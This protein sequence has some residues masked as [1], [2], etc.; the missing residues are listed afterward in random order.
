MLDASGHEVVTPLRKGPADYSLGIRSRRV[1]LLGEFAHCVWNCE[2]GDDRFLDLVAN[3][4]FDVLCHHAAEVGEYR[5]A[6]FDIYQAIVANTHRLR[7]VLRTMTKRGLRAAVS[8]GTVFQAG[9]G[10]GDHADR[11]VSAYGL[12]KGLSSQIFKFYCGEQHVS[13]GEFVIPN[14]FGPLEEARFCSYLVRCW[15]KGD[16]AKV[17]TPSYVRDNIHVSLLALVYTKFIEDLAQGDV[18]SRVCRPSG[19]VETQGDFAERFAREMRARL[20]LR[21]ELELAEQTE[22]PEPLVRINSQPA[23]DILDDVSLRESWRE[24]LAWQDLA[25]Y[26]AGPRP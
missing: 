18:T 6:D 5:S 17:N 1:D 20:N 25:D 22:F 24:D 26:Y 10:G 23:V 7:D 14:P 19:Y 4:D 9:E 11:A 3:D 12:S 2:F 21:C 8:T 13:H 15:Q 16:S